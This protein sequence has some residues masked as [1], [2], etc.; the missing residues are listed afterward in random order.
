MRYKHCTTV[1]SDILVHFINVGID[2]TYK[3]AIWC[4][5]WFILQLLRLSHLLT[6]L[7]VGVY[8]SPQLF[9]VWPLPCP[10]CSFSLVLFGL[11]VFCFVSVYLFL[12][13]FYAYQALVIFFNFK[14]SFHLS[15]VSDVVSVL[16]YLKPSLCLLVWT[17]SCLYDGRNT[18]QAGVKCLAAIPLSRLWW[19]SVPVVTI[20][21]DFRCTVAVVVFVL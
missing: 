12:L 10:E 20:N 14:L 4:L 1:S 5:S 13:L 11:V 2:A 9:V 16:L 18:K 3:L 21:V 7:V 15:I 19:L 6:H 17:M 8:T